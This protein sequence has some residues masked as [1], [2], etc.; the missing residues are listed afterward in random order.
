[1]LGLE[2]LRCLSIRKGMQTTRLKAGKFDKTN[3]RWSSVKCDVVERAETTASIK[4]LTYN[5]W[6]SDEFINE[7]SMA[8]LGILKD[9]DADFIALQEVTYTYFHRVNADHFQFCSGMLK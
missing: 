8:L 3:Q 2:S 9:C 4:L 7:R 1:M 5:I 6:F